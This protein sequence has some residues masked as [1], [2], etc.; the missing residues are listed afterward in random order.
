M[1]ILGKCLSVIGN[2]K[3]NIVIIFITQRRVPKRITVPSIQITGTF[4]AFSSHYNSL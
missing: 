1:I 4:A 3:K 2:T